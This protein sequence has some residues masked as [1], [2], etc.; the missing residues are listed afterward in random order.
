MVNIK[1]YLCGSVPVQNPLLEP[2]DCQRGY[3]ARAGQPGGPE[4]GLS[5]RSQAEGLREKALRPWWGAKYRPYM[6]HWGMDESFPSW[7]IRLPAMAH[8]G[9]A[10]PRLEKRVPGHT[11]EDPTPS[12]GR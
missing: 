5:R 4:N 8:R 6:K 10:C 3:A 1:A 2:L 7:E 9:A 11:G 12:D